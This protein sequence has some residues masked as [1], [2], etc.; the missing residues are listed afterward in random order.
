MKT[1]NEFKKINLDLTNTSVTIEKT[2]K[3]YVEKNGLNMSVLVRALLSDFIA[4][5]KNTNEKKEN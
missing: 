4:A 2:Q 3:A 1:L 5:Q